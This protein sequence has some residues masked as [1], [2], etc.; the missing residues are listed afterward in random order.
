VLTWISNRICDTIS[1]TISI[2][3]Y[4]G[5]EFAF[6]FKQIEWR[7]CALLFVPRSTERAGNFAGTVREDSTGL[8]SDIQ[9]VRVQIVLEIVLE[10]QWG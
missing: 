1:N 5:S 6:H 7:V 4:V 2:D 10:I 3:L 8:G 9:Y